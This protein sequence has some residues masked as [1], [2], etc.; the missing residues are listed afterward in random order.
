MD[1]PSAGWSVDSFNVG[2]LGSKRW[3]NS[4]KE[5]KLEVFCEKQEDVIVKMVRREFGLIDECSKKSLEEFTLG[6]FDEEY[7]GDNPPESD[8]IDWFPPPPRMTEEE[9]DVLTDWVE[10]EAEKHDLEPDPDTYPLENYFVTKEIHGKTD[11]P[12]Q[13]PCSACATS[14]TGSGLP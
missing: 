3:N 6:K 2:F 4:S 11:D 8:W 10:I 13:N 12:T 7:L 9:L 14:R 1:Q 5:E